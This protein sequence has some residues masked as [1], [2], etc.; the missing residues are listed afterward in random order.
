MNLAMLRA[1]G[2][3]EST[4]IPFTK[5][6]TVRCAQCEALVINGHPAHETGCDNARHECNGCN[7]LIP[8]RQRYCED[9]Q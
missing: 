5:Q 3:T 6:F 9:C 8:A 2:F 7:A 4:H 1:L